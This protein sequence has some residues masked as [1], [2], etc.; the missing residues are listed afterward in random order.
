MA[1]HSLRYLLLAALCL[2]LADVL[3]PTA[4]GQAVRPRFPNRNKPA[5]RPVL[6]DT[7]YEDNKAIVRIRT[8]YNASTSVSCNGV[9]MDTPNL[10]LSDVSCIKY[11]GMA[12]IDA[13][14]VQV[15]TGETFQEEYH[16]VDQIYINKANPNDPSTE[17]ALLR[18]RRPIQVETPCTDIKPPQL[19]T[20]YVPETN[21]RVI[22]YTQNNF[23]LKENR[24]RISRRVPPGSEK[25]VCTASSDLNETPGSQLMKGAPLFYQVDCKVYHMIGILT[26]VDTYFDGTSR[27]QQDCY[28]M[29]NS[30]TRW[31]NQVKSLASVALNA[32]NAPVSEPSVVVIDSE[33]IPSDVQT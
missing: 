5:D 19:N 31:Y 15:I 14:Y 11:Q 18:L 6:K 16:E 13:K 21:V 26:K 20:S 12:N 22:G 33:A 17:L 8:T 27:K 1:A 3:L 29:V 9:V 23:E 2:Q 30:Q 4:K 10:V 32:K 28:V 7:F 24:T 25:Y